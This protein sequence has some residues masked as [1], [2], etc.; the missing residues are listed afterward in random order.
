MSLD[1]KRMLARQLLAEFGVTSVT[2]RGNEMIV[3]CPLPFG[4][5]SNGDRNPSAAFNFEKLTFNCLG[6][7]NS[8]G[9]LWF[10]GACRGEESEQTRQWLTTQMGHDDSE[11]GVQKLLDWIDAVYSPE[12]GL[13]AQVM[14]KMSLRTLDPWLKLHPWVTEV[15]RVPAETAMAFRVGYGEFR[16]RVGDDWV[17][18]HRVVLPH[19]WRGDLVG[20]QT[21]R[22]IDDGT[23]KYLSSPDFPKD[24]TIFNHHPRQSVVVVE[25]MLSVLTKYHLDPHIEATFGAKVTDRQIELLSDHRDVTLWLDNDQAGWIATQHLGDALERYLP[26][27]VVPSPYAADVGDLDDST[28]RELLDQ[29]IP[30]A[31]WRP[32]DALTPWSHSC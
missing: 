19:I 23:P 8:G 7:Q 4:G 16:T 5:H 13:A 32:P 28:Y 14:P 21:R 2:E 27:W 10:I 9:L 6:C 15:R 11:E 26:V 1:E 22:L 24:L 29:R 20:W 30:Y 31:L 25:S 12:I 17:S 3:S 18:S